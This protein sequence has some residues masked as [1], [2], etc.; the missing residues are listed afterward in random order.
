MKWLSIRHPESSRLEFVRLCIK[1]TSRAVYNSRLPR[2]ELFSARVEGPELSR[3]YRIT[4]TVGSGGHER[5]NADDQLGLPR[6]VRHFSQEV[7]LRPGRDV[8][9]QLCVFS[10]RLNQDWQV[11]IGVCPQLEEL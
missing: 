8:S 9:L 11:G 1:R 6:S 4:I 2:T 5:C 10:L 7:E 3:G